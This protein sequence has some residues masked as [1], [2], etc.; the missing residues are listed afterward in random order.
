MG[1]R[2][3]ISIHGIADYLA[4]GKVGAE[5]TNSLK[6]DLKRVKVPA[7]RQRKSGTGS[8]KRVD[9]E[10]SKINRPTC[11]RFKLPLAS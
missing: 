7:R 11:L 5:Q 9:H 1:I 4:I 2:V 8:K 10:Q 3:G 6:G